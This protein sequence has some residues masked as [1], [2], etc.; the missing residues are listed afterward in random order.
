M[1]STASR[2]PAGYVNAGTL[3]L[4]GIASAERTPVLPNAPTI[5]ESGP[6]GFDNPVWFGLFAPAGTPAPIVQ[7]LNNQMN[8]ILA[9]PDVKQAFA[10]LGFEPGG[11][12]SDALAQ[13]VNSEIKKWTAL[14]KEKNIHVEP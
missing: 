11:G 9:M 1:R 14:V 13:R 12:S 7:K 5:A 3:R 4:L 6:P 10:K 2:P 8:G